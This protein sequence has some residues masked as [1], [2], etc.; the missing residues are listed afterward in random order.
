MLIFFLTRVQFKVRS[1]PLPRHQAPRWVDQRQRWTPG[2]AS[3][4]PV[5]LKVAILNL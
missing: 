2:E 4:P 5:I 3:D 1:L